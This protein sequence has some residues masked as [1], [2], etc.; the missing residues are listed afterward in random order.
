MDPQPE[1]I[2]VIFRPDN[3]AQEPNESFQLQLQ[4]ISPLPLGDNVFFQEFI[5]MNIQDGDG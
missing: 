4:P 2:T 5:E 1:Q 3:V